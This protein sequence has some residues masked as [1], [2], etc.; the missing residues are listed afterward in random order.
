MIKFV[1]KKKS[2]ICLFK[3]NSSRNN[4]LVLLYHMK[5]IREM[6]HK[7]LSQFVAMRLLRCSGWLWACC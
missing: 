4:S 3:H 6:S 1:K 7:N 5:N 2:N